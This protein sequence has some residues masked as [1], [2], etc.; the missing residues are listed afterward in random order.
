[1][2]ADSDSDSDSGSD[3]QGRGDIELPHCTNRTEQSIRD[4]AFARRD[5]RLGGGLEEEDW[6]RRERQEGWGKDW[7]G[8]RREVDDDDEDEP[9]TAG[10]WRKDGG[11]KPTTKETTI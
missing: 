11:R 2:N 1:M 6:K 5:A 4:G 8:P 7:E 3:S 10:T 9:S